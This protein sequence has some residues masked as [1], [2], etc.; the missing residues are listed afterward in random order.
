MGREG[1][2]ERK[3]KGKGKGKHKATEEKLKVSYIL[4][5]MI[6]FSGP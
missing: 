3:M 2:R 6:Q 4:R 5:K 1:G